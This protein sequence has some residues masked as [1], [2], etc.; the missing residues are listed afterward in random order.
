MYPNSHIGCPKYPYNPR[1][2]VFCNGN[3]WEYFCPSWFLPQPGNGT[4][5]FKA[6]GNDIYIGLFEKIGILKFQYA[7][8][9]SGWNNT[10]IHLYKNGDWDN[11]IHEEYYHLEDTKSISEWAITFCKED[12]S[13]NVRHQGKTVFHF[14][15]S[16]YNASNAAYISFSQYS[17]N[18]VIHE[19]E[20]MLPI[21]EAKM[22]I[23]MNTDIDNIVKYPYV[24][25]S[26]VF[27]GAPWDKFYPE[28]R[29]P[30]PGMGLISFTAKGNDIYVGLF[31]EPNTKKFQYGIIISG[32]NNTEAKVYK[33]GNWSKEVISAPAIIANPKQLNKFGI[34]FNSRKETVAVIINSHI[35]LTFYDPNYN[36]S[37]AQWISLSQYGDNVII[38]QVDVDYSKAS[39]ISSLIGEGEE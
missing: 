19:V 33:N 13:V 4:V 6:Q 20:A 14:K 18:V 22:E 36:A 5:T 9:I 39:L 28:W 30:V 15:D 24:P 11:S 27:H 12:S 26:G 34:L 38:D 21:L 25:R 16:A 23:K 8:I 29:L 2:G 1:N 7:L 10:F 37:Q 17:G 35:V 3:T 32:W 31:N